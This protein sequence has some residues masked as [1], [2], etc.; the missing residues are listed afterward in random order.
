LKIGDGLK[1]FKPEILASGRLV[2][3]IEPL[4]PPSGVVL[5]GLEV[6]VRDVRANLAA[7]AALVELQR[8]PDDEDSV[9]ERLVGFDPQEA[10]A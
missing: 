4:R 9:P 10:L 3:G 2:L 6:E 7:K 8:A 1:F 5:R